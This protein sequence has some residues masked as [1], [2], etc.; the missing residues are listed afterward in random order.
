MNTYEHL[1]LFNEYIKDYDRRIVYL[2]LKRALL[3]IFTKCI[4]LTDENMDKGDIV[5]LSSTDPNVS[6][7]LVL[8]YKIKL[9]DPF[10]GDIYYSYN[11]S[12]YCKIS[13]N[14]T[15]SEFPNSVELLECT[16]MD[17]DIVVEIKFKVLPECY[18][19][20]T[21]EQ[22]FLVNYILKEFINTTTDDDTPYDLFHSLIV[23]DDEDD[24]D[25]S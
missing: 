6:F 11:Y 8:N 19:N 22:H 16:C 10:R 13:D 25:D 21:D 23:E 1:I 18:D 15:E 24:E 17:I 3:Y 5:K 4:V 7:Y 2:N 14:N 20:F 12:L 9:N